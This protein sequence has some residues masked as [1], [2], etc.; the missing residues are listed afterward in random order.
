M[1]QAA[2]LVPRPQGSQPGRAD[3]GS[4]HARSQGPPRWAD[5]GVAPRPPL[6]DS[7]PLFKPARHDGRQE[8]L[9]PDRP[10]HGSQ[11]DGGRYGWTAPPTSET[12]VAR[13]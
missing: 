9:S 7:L 1:P 6:R 3:S 2:P 5:A 4:G 13:R 10:R 8:G 11:A 12:P